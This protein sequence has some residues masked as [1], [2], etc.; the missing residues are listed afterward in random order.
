MRFPSE[1][2]QDG[3]K[4]RVGTLLATATCHTLSSSLTSCR[5]S[6]SC[7]LAARHLEQTIFLSPTRYPPL[8]PHL[9]QS[10]RFDYTNCPPPH[11]VGFRNRTTHSSYRSLEQISDWSIQHFLDM[12]AIFEVGVSTVPQSSHRCPYRLNYPHQWL[13]EL[14]VPHVRSIPR[15]GRISIA[16]SDPSLA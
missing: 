2:I 1:E 10:P 12:N 11:L 4:D 6:S 8:A 14:D 7:N 15:A 3:I 5:P 13:K 9:V 16:T